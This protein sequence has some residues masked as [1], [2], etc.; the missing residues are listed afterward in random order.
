MLGIAVAVVL[1]YAIYRGGAK[2]NM[3]RFFRVTGLVLVVVSP[4]AW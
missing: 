1:G 4:P 2:I 3:A